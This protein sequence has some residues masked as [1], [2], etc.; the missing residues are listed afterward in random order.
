M[1]RELRGVSALLK[2]KIESLEYEIKCLANTDVPNTAGVLD[3]RARRLAE[4][5]REL[6]RELVTNRVIVLGTIHEFQDVGHPKNKELEARLS[7]L[8]EKFAVTMLMEEWTEKKQAS[9]ASK[10]AKDAVAY[11]NVGTPPEA[12]FRTF[13]FA[14]VHHPYHDGMLRNC[15]DAPPMSEHGPLDNQENREQRMLR[16]I[17]S[18]MEDRTV[19]L[20]IVGHGHIHSMSIKLKKAGF[21]VTA[22]G[23]L[24]Q[25]SS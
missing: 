10:L 19:G 14:H 4:L 1:N 8:I 3:E 12:E 7:F 6:D 13:R 9:F 2:E 11:R 21:N 23:W 18:A 17:Q 25:E 15:D 16:T 5:R 20:F 24:G 22:Y